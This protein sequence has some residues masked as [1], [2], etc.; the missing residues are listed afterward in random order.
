LYEDGL[1]RFAT[2]EYVSPNYENID[3]LCMHLTNYAINKDNPN[4]VFNENADD[5]DVGHKRSLKAV[6]RLLEEEGHDVKALWEEIKRIII[7]TFC[8]V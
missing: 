1:G 2:E 3:N 6:F 7:K 5:D 4:F 8:C